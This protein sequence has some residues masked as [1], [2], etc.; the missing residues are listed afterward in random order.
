MSSEGII[1]SDAAL[2]VV[3]W[4]PIFLICIHSPNNFLL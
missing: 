3:S 2:V 4:I 1:Q